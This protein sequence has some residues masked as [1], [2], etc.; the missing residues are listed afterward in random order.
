M[1]L[2]SMLRIAHARSA[3]GAPTM[4]DN[5]DMLATIRSL[6]SNLEKLVYLYQTARKITEVKRQQAKGVAM[7]EREDL[8]DLVDIDIWVGNEADTNSGNLN[9]FVRRLTVEH[10]STFMKTIIYT[11]RSF[12]T[13]TK[14]FHKLSRRFQVPPSVEPK[15]ALAIQL[16]VGIV[17]K[18]WLQ[19]S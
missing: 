2:V 13:P 14:L 19:V 18:F 5:I 10:D 7:L 17:V 11:H 4:A 16:R 6:A 1:R 12:T 15:A 3:S 9:S 8:D